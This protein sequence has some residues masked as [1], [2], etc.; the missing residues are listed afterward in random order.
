MSDKFDPTPVD[1]HA[2]DPRRA[3]KADKKRN[4]LDEGPEDT[5]PA[6]DP[7]SGA[8]PQPSKDLKAFS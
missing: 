8:Q 7:A 5:Y 6:S 4:D 1:K 3:I 2:V